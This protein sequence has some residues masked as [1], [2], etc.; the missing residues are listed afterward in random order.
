MRQC[1]VCDEYT[2]EVLCHVCGFDFSRDYENTPTFAPTMSIAARRKAWQERLES[3]KQEQEWKAERD[4]TNN[5]LKS[6]QADN[7]RLRSQ[8]EQEKHKRRNAESRARSA[9]E[10]TVLKAEYEKKLK[11]AREEVSTARNEAQKVQNE[12]K[13]E[14]EK[15]LW[16]R[17]ED[18]IGT[19]IET[20]MDS[21]DALSE[22]FGEFDSFIDV[23]MG[24]PFIVIY[25]LLP[26]LGILLLAAPVLTAVYGLTALGHYSIFHVP[27]WSQAPCDPHVACFFYRCSLDEYHQW[28]DPS[29]LEPQTCTVCGEK[30]GGTDAH[31]WG[32]VDVDGVEHCILCD[33]QRGNPGF[34]YS[35]VAHESIQTD[36]LRNSSTSKL[37]TFDDLSLFPDDGIYVLNFCGLR[38]EV[39]TSSSENQLRITFSDELP[40]GRYSVYDAATDQKLANLYYC[41]HKTPFPYNV[42]DQ[43]VPFCAE[44]LLTGQYL[45]SADG[46]L[47]M[48]DDHADAQYF[49]ETFA[50]Q[51]Y[52][53]WYL[54][55]DNQW[56]TL[57]TFQSNGRY[58][59]ANSNG[60]VYW[61]NEL[62]DECYWLIHEESD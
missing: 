59:A 60:T 40:M 13:K 29:C 53:N 6:A 8:L 55:Q 28:D 36:N 3:T 41:K 26:L 23:I 20:L 27:Q 58:L 11:K 1:P 9:A 5:A 12:L 44:N 57:H 46:T 47:S 39:E 22:Q 21:V 51:H 37:L 35:Q 24:F 10:N 14:Q 50:K 49:E 62:T 52:L 19:L 18:F 25:A 16:E 61:S 45:T 33:A 54:T 34:F 48:T 30:Q 42:S 38:E 7:Q 56:I 15:N 4:L 31:V 43:F 32:S 17:Y 2:S